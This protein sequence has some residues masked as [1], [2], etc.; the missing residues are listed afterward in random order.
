[1]AQ[2]KGLHVQCRG[3]QGW[4]VLD[5]NLPS[6]IQASERS[7]FDQVTWIVESARV[8]REDLIVTDIHVG[9]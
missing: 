2:A 8:D 4:N 5:E 7:A 9:S 1:M 3:D 6:D